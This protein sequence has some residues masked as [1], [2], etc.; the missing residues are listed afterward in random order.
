MPEHQQLGVLGAAVAGELGS[1]PADNPD[2]QLVFDDKNL[3]GAHSS[4]RLSFA[5][6]DLDPTVLSDVACVDLDLALRLAGE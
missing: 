5:G 6:F 1:T 4:V 2:V 3:S